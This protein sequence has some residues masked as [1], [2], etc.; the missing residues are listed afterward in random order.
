MKL[1]RPDRGETDAY[2]ALTPAMTRPIRWDLIEQ[3]YDMAVKY[4]T[5]IHSGQHPPKRSCAVSHA[6]VPPDV[7]G[8]AGDR[9]R[10][11]TIFVANY[12]RDRDQQRDTEAGLNPI[13]NWNQ[14]NGVICFG[15]GGEL[16]S[17]RRD[18]Q[19]LSMLALHGLSQPS[20]TSTRSLSKT[21]SPTG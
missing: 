12:L 19:E 5:A 14:G 2:P 17:N 6:I 4:A 11:R 21:S 15:K 20:S 1:Y 10:E 7:R 9:T 3:Y 8:N 13:E 18:H 16:S